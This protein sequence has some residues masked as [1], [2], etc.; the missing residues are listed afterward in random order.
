[1]ETGE[2]WGGD[3]EHE[4]VSLGRHFQRDME[5]LWGEI[6]KMAAVVEV[7]LQ[8][9][10]RALCD[11]RPDLAAEVRGSEKDINDWEVRI[12]RECLRILALHQPVASDL[13]R[14]AVVL[15]LDSELERMGDL[16]E[17]IAKRVRKLARRGDAPPVSPELETLAVEALAQ[18]RDS[19]DAL[20]KSDAALARAVIA[21]DRRLDL[22]HRAVATQLKQ[23]IRR[24]PDRINVWFLLYN[25]ARNL[26]R[27]ADHATNI[28]EAVIYL[29][30]G[31]IVRHVGPSQA[32][33]A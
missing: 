23:D 22:H 29:K 5:G 3:W 12:E 14:V 19:L 9:S 11:S 4:R 30:E 13:R 27:I 28:A 17:H 33:R 16:A 24:D 8:T 32:A 2:G 26:E 25:T 20:A 10:V 31:D 1:M 7:A 6:L 15:K 21:S 18:V